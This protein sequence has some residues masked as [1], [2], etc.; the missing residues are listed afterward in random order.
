MKIFHT[1]KQ[2]LAFFMPG[3]LFGVLYVNFFAVKYMAQPGIFSTYF[4]EQYQSVDIVAGEYLWYLIR[5]RVFPFLVLSGLALT[6]AR[7]AA[8]VLFLAWTGISGGILFSLAVA[9]IGNKRKHSVYY[10]NASSVFIL[11]SGLSGSYLVCLQLSGQSLEPA[12]NYFHFFY[13]GGRTYS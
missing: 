11:Y 7:K 10:G 3:F 1:R 2:L 12:E 4:L 8:A 9:D 6:K 5:V 13:D